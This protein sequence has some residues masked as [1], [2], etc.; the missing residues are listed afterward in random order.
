MSPSLSGPVPMTCREQGRVLC[1]LVAG[2][3]QLYSLVSALPGLDF[4]RLLGEGLVVP[5]LQAS[6]RRALPP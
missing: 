4:R 1:F 3:L 5:L 2:S 6:L